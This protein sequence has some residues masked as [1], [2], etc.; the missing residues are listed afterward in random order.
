MLVPVPSSVRSVRARGHDATALLGSGAA[1]HLAREGMSAHSVRVLRQRKGVVDQSGLS[2]VA[3]RTNA[4]GGF[5]LTRLGERELRR[6]TCGGGV[7]VLLV[8]DIVTTGSTLA[9]AAQ[10]L[11]QRGIGV[12]GFAV[13]AETP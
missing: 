7:A 6:R 3:R 2:A 11:L 1:A 10:A 5:V 4:C 8:D 12:D 9:G 13:V